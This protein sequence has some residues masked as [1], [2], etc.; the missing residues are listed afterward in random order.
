LGGNRKEKD[1]AKVQEYFNTEDRKHLILA[2]FMLEMQ[3]YARCNN[4]KRAPPSLVLQGLLLKLSHTTQ[5]GMDLMSSFKVAIGRTV[6]MAIQKEISKVYKEITLP[7]FLKNT[8]E[9]SFI[10]IRL[11]NYVPL[12]FKI[13]R[14]QRDN[15]GTSLLKSV[16]SIMA[17]YSTYDTAKEELASILG[18]NYHTKILNPKLTKEAVNGM[19]GTSDSNCHMKRVE[20]GR[21]FAYEGLM[22][23]SIA[24]S[25]ETVLKDVICADGD[26]RIRDPNLA[27]DN[28]KGKFGR[29][30]DCEHVFD[31]MKAVDSIQRVDCYLWD[32]EGDQCFAWM[33]HLGGVDGYDKTKYCLT[34]LA[35]FHQTKNMTEQWFYST[36]PLAANLLN[37]F[38]ETAYAS[39]QYQRTGL[40]DQEFTE[41]CGTNL[42]RKGSTRSSR[43]KRRRTRASDETI[44]MADVLDRAERGLQN[45]SGEGGES[46]VN[47]EGGVGGG[48]EEEEEDLML[49][50]QITTTTT[51]GTTPGE[52]AV[53]AEDDGGG[54]GPVTAMATLKDMKRCGKK[55][56]VKPLGYGRIKM[57]ASTLL[58]VWVEGIDNRPGARQQVLDLIL[59]MQSYKEWKDSVY[60]TRDVE[61]PVPGVPNID[62]RIDWAC[63][64]FPKFKALWY[65]LDNQFRSCVE[66]GLE[67][68]K[69]GDLQCLLRSLPFQVLS[70]IYHHRYLL[71]RVTVNFMAAMH[72]M[73]SDPDSYTGVLQFFGNHC[74]LYCVVFL[75]SFT[76]NA[77]LVLFVFDVC[78]CCVVCRKARVCFMM[79]SLNM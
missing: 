29:Y 66:P 20:E 75:V 55:P 3:C 41:Q 77:N 62:P 8:E 40:T 68:E 34:T 72:M 21:I 9:L 27:I 38:K 37:H 31:K 35:M 11:D 71:A 15:E 6:A 69:H 65:S 63:E 26:P 33:K 54:G 79:A 48:E 78:V 2:L 18:V 19:F 4:S 74:E 32:A 12:F 58:H 43:R 47:G 49:L 7:R 61:E 1:I 56:K 17:V 51:L 53:G 52:N 5:M 70:Q 64:T 10:L 67:I 60:S 45:D 13:L 24:A 39:E 28:H 50:E 46:G 73:L 57:G 44:T 14:T 76:L 59:R 23:S 25:V 36:D 30:K 42:L 16:D 22:N